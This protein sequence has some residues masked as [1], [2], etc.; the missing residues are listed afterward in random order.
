MSDPFIGEIQIFGC[1]FAPQHWIPCV[2]GMLQI[3]QYQALY[4]IV[5][6]YFGGDGRTTFGLPN[7][8]GHAPMGF[9]QGT[10]LTYREFGQMYGTAGVVLGSDNLPSHNHHLQVIYA[11]GESPS[12][13]V[14]GAIAVDL[15][16]G[17]SRIRFANNDAQQSSTPMAQQTLGVTGQSAPHE[18]RQPFLAVNFCMATV[19][20]YP[21]RN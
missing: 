6:T 17:D 10:N 11:N 12:P 18:N 19:G 14:D 20:Y 1:S 2:H 9:D 21:S 13:V 5:G 4:S 7:L 8:V 15:P 3:N 16:R